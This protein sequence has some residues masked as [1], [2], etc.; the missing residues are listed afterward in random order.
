MDKRHLAD[1]NEDVERST[2]SKALIFLFV[3]AFGARTRGRLFLCQTR[4]MV[5]GIPRPRTTSAPPRGSR[6]LL[7]VMRE[8]EDK[9]HHFLHRRRDA[10]GMRT[11]RQWFVLEDFLRIVLLH[12]RGI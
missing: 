2:Y 1:Y 3:L 11:I 8:L 6:F 9:I 4:K 5:K 12:D 7:V 10:V